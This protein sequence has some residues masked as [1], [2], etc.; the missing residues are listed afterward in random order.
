MFSEMKSTQGMGSN[1]ASTA[2]SD[3]RGGAYRG[4]NAFF[5]TY[6]QPNTRR[7]DETMTASYCHNIP[8]LQPCVGETSTRSYYEVRLSARGNHTGG[9]NAALGDGSV[10]FVSD[11]IAINVW[12]A[13]GTARGGESVSL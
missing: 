13:A 11:T 8:V 7:A 3:F 1:G 2:F 6:Y 4:D 10:Q 5:T 9:V 12:R